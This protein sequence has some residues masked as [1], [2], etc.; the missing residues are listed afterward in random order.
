MFL[1][2][3][4][5]AADLAWYFLNA[6]DFFFG[7]YRHVVQPNYS[8]EAHFDLERESSESIRGTVQTFGWFGLL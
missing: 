5:N 2:S 8:S 1:C 7:C 6:H 3:L 4:T